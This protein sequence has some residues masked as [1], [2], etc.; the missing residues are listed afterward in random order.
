M[1]KNTEHLGLYEKE[2]TDGNDTFNVQAMMNDNWD[3]IDQF[4]K[5]TDDKI[6]NLGATSNSGNA[7]SVSAP[8]SFILQDGQLLLVKFNADSTGAISLNVGGTGAK[9]VKDYF[10][11]PVTNVSA[12][13]P[14]ILSYES[15][16]DSFI[17]SGKGGDGTAVSNDIRLGKTATT[18]NG[19]VTGTLDLSNVTSDNLRSGVVIDGVTGKSSV[20]DT[21]DGTATAPQIRQG[22]TAYVNGAKVT[23]TN[24]VQATGAQTITPG[25]SDVVK[26]AGIYDGDITIKGDI[27]LVASNV[28]SG[29]S[30][31][32][33]AG[34]V[35]EKQEFSDYLKNYNASNLQPI[36]YFENE[37]MWASKTDTA[38]SANNIAILYNN[39][40][41]I[42]KQV[43]NP[44]STGCYLPIQVSKNYILWLG[45]G[46]FSQ[47]I[48]ITDKNGTIIKNITL[49]NSPYSCGFK[50]VSGGLRIYCESANSFTIYDMNGNQIGYFTATHGIN[51]CTAYIPT[52]NGMIFSGGATGS[53]YT[54][55]VLYIN[56]S[57][58]T[59]KDIF[60]SAS[61]IISCMFMFSNSL[62][63]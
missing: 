12:D 24:P 42:V 7:Y 14:A 55:Y 35:E 5:N 26:P 39:I 61:A 4:A 30:I 49:T 36:G 44:D 3:K 2:S 48:Q 8:S 11:N 40:G 41:N 22:Q 19:L 51:Y 53:P 52:K 46:S 29:K 59:F 47:H 20:I 62:Q 16:S 21:A 31:F 56:D 33:V 60:Y 58:N 23:G 28:I 50:E 34:I 18:K 32:G 37:G 43:I 57:D 25:T 38:T 27:N 1:A 6:L 15:S 54:S 9:S 13:L 63:L 17:L 10:K 45:H